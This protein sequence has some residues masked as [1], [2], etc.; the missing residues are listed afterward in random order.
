MEI[1]LVDTL[2]LFYNNIRLFLLFSALVILISPFI[3]SSEMCDLSDPRGCG[4]YDCGGNS[5]YLDNDTGNNGHSSLRS[6]FIDMVG[7]SRLC[8]NVTGPAMVNFSWKVEPTSHRVGSLSFLVDGK[9]AGVCESRSWV[10]VS[11]PIRDDKSHR[12]TW[13]FRKIKSFPQNRG[14]GWI[15]DL[16]ILSDVTHSE[17]NASQYKQGEEN[18]SGANV[19]DIGSSGWPL[20]GNFFINSSNI[21]I[22]IPNINISSSKIGNITINGEHKEISSNTSKKD[23]RPCTVIVGDCNCTLG[24]GSK[25]YETIKDAIESVCDD[26]DIFI[27]PGTYREKLS[28]NKCLKLRGEN[29]AT[30]VIEAQDGEII[31]VCHE[32]VTIENLSLRNSGNLGT[33][34]VKIN[35]SNNFILNNCDIINCFK[36]IFIE[37]SD[38]VT[39]SWN[40]I[41][42][43]SSKDSNTPSC[44]WMS[45]N[46]FSVA[47][48]LKDSKYAHIFDNTMI[49]RNSTFPSDG[50]EYE[51]DTKRES[52]VTV[53]YNETQWRDLNNFNV[54]CCNIRR[55]GNCQ[56]SHI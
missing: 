13:E 9:T 25:R 6:G 30:T 14:A 50:I 46:K 21:S 33:V 35:S 54:S 3:A 10:P 20:P 11:Y 15:K 48:F 32:N 45:T 29:N 12:L 16:E 44:T 51:F 47:I 40:R 26:G 52:P 34:G 53:R 19:A 39:L 2:K 17:R 5:W 49:L 4:L 8:M 38:N 22:N 31:K 23:D 18:A 1:S 28:I 36:G 42:M 24:F 27:C 7:F 43:L 55:N 56:T 41:S 37:K